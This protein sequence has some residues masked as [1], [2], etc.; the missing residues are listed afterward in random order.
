MKPARKIKATYSSLTGRVARGKGEKA[1]AFESALERDLLIVC[2]F[3]PRVASFNEQPF[4]IEFVHEGKDRIYYPDLLITYQEWT[5]RLPQLCEV[6]YRADLSKNWVDLKPKLKAG[7]RY[8][9]ENG[10]TFKIYT[11]VEIRTPYLYN[12]KFFESFKHLPFSDTQ[13]KL[14][15]DAFRKLGTSNAETVLNDLFIDN[16]DRAR[17]V[18]YLWRMIA[19]GQVWC[20]L[21]EPLTMQSPLRL[22]EG[23]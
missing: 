5:G 11:E 8:A 1:A 15:V 17:N 4:K 21:G 19:L 20:D 12:A 10:Y 2:R 22:Q 3:N 23:D 7:I 16:Y 9:R 14:F 13:H 6:K 18:P